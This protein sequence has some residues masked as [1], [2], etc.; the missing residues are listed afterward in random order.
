MN[1]EKIKI[2]FRQ[3]SL[4]IFYGLI[5]YMPVHI[6][7][8]TIIGANFGG[9]E[10]LKIFKDILLVVGFIAIFVSS[11]KQKWFKEWLSDSIV[12]AILLYAFL[13]IV[14]ALIKPTDLD[15]EILGVTYNLRF[16]LFFL[17]GWLLVRTF[18]KNEIKTTTLKLV[19]SSSF[20]VVIFGIIQYLLLPNDAL[21][22]LGFTKAN[23]VFPA[24]FI[25]DKPDLERVMSTLRDPNSLGSY[26][27]IISSLVIAGFVSAKNKFKKSWAIYGLLTLLCLWFTFSRSA[28][29]GLILMIGIYG[30]LYLR[31]NNKLKSKHLKIGGIGLLVSIM[32]FGGILF[33]ARNSYFVQNVIFHAD[34]STTL[35]DPN[36][37]RIRFW[38][39]SVQEV[40]DAPLGNGPGTAG[41]ASIK[42]DKQG[43]KLNENYY[44]Q[45]ASEVGIIGL[46][47][48]LSII[49][50]IVIRIYQAHPNNY[51]VYAL[52]ASLAGLMFT[53][54]LVHIWSNEA[55]A[56]TWWGLAGLVISSPTNKK[57]TV[58]KNR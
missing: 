36:E 45:V 27:I 10:F 50:L 31:S 16:L 40:A 11:L 25:D 43:T 2:Q 57:T 32:L 23:G 20:V 15:A 13:T 1:I 44:L 17:Y 33:F 38:K 12:V 19:L 24:F 4:Y 9:L 34:S 26:L 41:L 8:S 18:P 42:N 22:A 49:I 47:L 35:E 53:N 39:E 46:V 37:L 5:A 29:I 30:A 21:K 55:V 14:L 28:L 56:Y 51:F 6:F 54:F 7:V 52:L 48:F 3:V 58:V